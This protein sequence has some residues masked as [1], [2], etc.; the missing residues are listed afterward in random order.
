MV[1]VESAREYSNI[2]YAGRVKTAKI[3]KKTRLKQGKVK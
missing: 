2:D 3:K 1:V